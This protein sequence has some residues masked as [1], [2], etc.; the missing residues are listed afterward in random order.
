MGQTTAG[1]AQRT[2][3]EK[4]WAREK[5]GRVMGKASFVVG[6]SWVTMPD[7]AWPRGPGAYEWPAWPGVGPLLAG[8]VCW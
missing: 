8:T 7:G 6:T 1:Q 3:A 5:A 2:Q 4:P